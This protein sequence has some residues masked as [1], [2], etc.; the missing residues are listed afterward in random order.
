MTPSNFKAYYKATVIKMA[1]FGH[2]DRSMEQ[3]SNTHK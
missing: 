2:K 3:N 1:W